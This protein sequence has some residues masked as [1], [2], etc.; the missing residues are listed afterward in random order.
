MGDEDI[1][2]EFQR[3][4][5]S[6]GVSAIDP[7]TLTEVSIAGPASAGKEALTRAVMRKVAYVLEKKRAP[8]LVVHVGADN[9]GRR[10]YGHGDAPAW[11]QR[12]AMAEDFGETDDLAVIGRR[13]EVAGL[14]LVD[15]GCGDGYVLEQPIRAND[16][17]RLKR[18]D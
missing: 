12:H 13:L 10:R 2:I 4:G 17:R 8:G 9:P 16:V 14:S 5:A 1:I 18:P 3:I 11:P 7:E 15:A 6:V